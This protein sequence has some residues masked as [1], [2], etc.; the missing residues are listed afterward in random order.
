[1]YSDRKKERA[2]EYLIIVGILVFVYYAIVV[3]FGHEAEETPAERDDLRHQSKMA[4]LNEHPEYKERFGLNDP[5]VY[6]LLLGVSEYEREDCLQWAFGD[7]YK[8]LKFSAL[9]DRWR[10]LH[11]DLPTLLGYHPIESLA[12]LVAEEWKK[13]TFGPN[14]PNEAVDGPRCKW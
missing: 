5:N 11:S 13:V 2:V 6:D 8:S 7:D 1:M 9:D 12:E 10:D 4:F 14:E 3:L